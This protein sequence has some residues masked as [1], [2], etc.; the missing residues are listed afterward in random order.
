MLFQNFK[1]E[2]N[3]ARLLLC[4][5]IIGATVMISNVW[6]WQS[7]YIGIMAMMLML[8]QKVHAGNKPQRVACALIIV[9]AAMA[10]LADLYQQNVIWVAIGMGLMA[11][12]VYHLIKQAMKKSRTKN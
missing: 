1:K 3:V 4:V 10:W 11:G 12:A 5:Q 2:E 7:F 8:A 9:G 6:M